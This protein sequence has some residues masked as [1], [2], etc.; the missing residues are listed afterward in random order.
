MLI[1]LTL[2]FPLAC[3]SPPR[4]TATYS[5]PDSSDELGSCDGTVV[6]SPLGGEC[7][8]CCWFGNQNECEGVYG[9]PCP[10]QCVDPTVADATCPI[11]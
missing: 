1:V 9:V 11:P 7:D 6:F 4:L 3:S 8:A 10:P 5:P 2:V